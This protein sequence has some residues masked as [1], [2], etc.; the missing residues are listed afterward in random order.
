MCLWRRVSAITVLQREAIEKERERE[1]KRE[2]KRD[3]ERERERHE[4]ATASHLCNTVICNTV[5]AEHDTPLINHLVMRGFVSGPP[6]YRSRHKI[7]RER[8]RSLMKSS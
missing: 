6:S 4:H 8:K 1:R 3:R 2:R 7:V 5:T